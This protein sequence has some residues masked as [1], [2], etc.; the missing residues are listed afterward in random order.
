MQTDVRMGAA[1]WGYQRE[2]RPCDAINHSLAEAKE[3][4]TLTGISERGSRTLEI[5]SG[6]GGFR[7]TGHRD[8]FSGDEGL[9]NILLDCFR[10][11]RAIMLYHFHIN[12]KPKPFFK[13]SFPAYHLRLWHVTDIE[14]TVEVQICVCVRH[15]GLHRSV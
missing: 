15:V 12:L 3:L 8:S 4:L 14:V 11:V 7:R 9:E 6:A 2:A 13:S 10:T 1:G 5:P